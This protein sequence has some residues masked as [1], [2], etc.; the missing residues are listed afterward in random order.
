MTIDEPPIPT[1]SGGTAGLTVPSRFVYLGALSA[2]AL[3][4]IVAG[5]SSVLPWPASILGLAALGS[6][7][8]PGAHWLALGGGGLFAVLVI[9]FSLTGVGNVGRADSPAPTDAS[10]PSQPVAAAGSLSLKIGEI[11]ELWNGLGHPPAMTRGLVMETQAGQYDSFQYRFDSAASLAGAYDPSDGSVHALMASI[12]LAH[13]AAPYFYLHLCFM[14]HPYSQECIDAYLEEGLGG[15]Q[16]ADYAGQ[17]HAVQWEFDGQVWKL[18]IAGD[19][20]TI[21]VISEAA[22]A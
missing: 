9:V 12:G 11:P 1:S 8:I 21:R 2:S 14:L 3:L 6:T 17:R 13:Q 20:Q 22:D 7:R 15:K 5:M 4:L 19:I 18:E 16:I 10:A